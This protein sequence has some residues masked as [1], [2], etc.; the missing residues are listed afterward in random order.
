M[1]DT[2]NWRAEC[3]YGFREGSS[4]GNATGTKPKASLLEG[5]AFN[6]YENCL[7]RY[8]PISLTGYQ[9]YT[10]GYDSCG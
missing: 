2:V 3:S 8:L 9:E 5:L 6:L 10:P 4:V 7:S 1:V